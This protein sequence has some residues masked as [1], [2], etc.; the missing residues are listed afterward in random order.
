LNRGGENDNTAFGGAVEGV[1]V[2]TIDPAVSWSEVTAVV[3]GL[4]LEDR[5]T[6]PAVAQRIC[7]PGPTA[8]RKWPAV[9]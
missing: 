8:W 1:A 9:L 6:E 5:E 7:S 4:V 2:M 3:Y